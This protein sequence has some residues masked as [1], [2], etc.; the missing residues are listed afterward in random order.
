MMNKIPI[1][2][3]GYEK[4]EEEHK[5]LK[6]VERPSIIEQIST[7]RDHGDLRE[8][9]EYHAAREKQSFT[10]GRIQELENIIANAEIIDV[11]KLSGKK[12]LFGATVDVV[13]C[14]TDEEKTYQIVGEYE[15]DLEKGKISNTAPIARALIGKEEGDTV[16]FLSPS[17]KKEYEILKISFK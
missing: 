17:G 12:V 13:D 11:S 15:A 2:K 16:T 8:N 7:A 6:F 14:Q 1:T 9:A 3:I 5:H 4:L 10:E